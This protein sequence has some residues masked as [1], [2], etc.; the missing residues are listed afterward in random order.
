[1]LLAPSVVATPSVEATPS[2]DQVVQRVLEWKIVWVRVRPVAELV[3][4]EDF[5][6]DCGE[7]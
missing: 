7:E 2:V 4:E 5:R 1:M 3:L 6:S